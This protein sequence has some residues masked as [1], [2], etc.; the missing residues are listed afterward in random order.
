MKFDKTKYIIKTQNLLKTSCDGCITLTDEKTYNRMNL[1]FFNFCKSLFIPAHKSFYNDIDLKILDETRTIVPSGWFY[2]GGDLDYIQLKIST[3]FFK[4]AE[5]DISKAFTSMFLKMDEKPVFNQFDIWKPYDGKINEHHDLTLYYVKSN[6]VEKT[7]MLLNKKYGILYGSILKE[8]INDVDVEILYFKTPSQIHKCNHQEII[9]ELWSMTISDDIDEDKYIKKLIANVNFGLLEKG[10]STDQKSL[11]FKNL[12]EALDY[13]V[14]YGGRLH[15]LSDDGVEV[16]YIEYSNGSTQKLIYPVNTDNYYILNLK[17]QAQLKNGFRYIKELLLQLHNYEMYKAYINLKQNNAKI[18]SVKTDAFV[19][20]EKD[21]EPARKLLNFSDEIGGWRVSKY[22]EEIKFPTVI[23]EVVENELINIPVYKSQELPVKNEYDTD[24]II[25]QIKLNNP[26]MIRGELPGTGKSYI[27]QKMVEKDYKVIFV[28]PTNKLLQAFEGEAST[29]NKFFGISFGD[30]KLEPFDYSYFDVIVFDEI[31]FSSLSTYW[32]I[33]QFV[34]QNK[35]S[36]IIIATGDTKQL[37][38]IQALTNIQDY[39]TYADHI[40]NNIFENSI[41]VKECKRLHTQEDKDKLNNIKYDW[42]INKLPLKKWIEKYFQYTADISG[43][44]N[45]IAYLNDTCKN[46]AN[47]IRKLEN[48]T[49]EY[50]V[51]EFL[52][53]REYTKTNNCVFNVNFQYE[54]VCVDNKFLK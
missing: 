24:S 39:E 23:Y 31:Y 7:K 43:S 45:N 34:E 36:K 17:D 14:N 40:I 30:V 5:I 37:K 6:N 22:N 54:I 52:I 10:G 51:G 42:F 50:E 26:M 25:E 18:Y 53:C 47:E 12:N 46:V 9:D 33:K 4:V 28:C 1:A 27:C 15:K 20:R 2:S 13:Q 8:V 41:L 35:D 16:K 38:P 3:G 11:L 32:R 48:R 21:V 19:I 49:G 29:L 44:K